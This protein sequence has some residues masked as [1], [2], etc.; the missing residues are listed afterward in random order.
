MVVGWIIMARSFFSRCFSVQMEEI[1]ALSN[2]FLAAVHGL[3][4]FS[5]EVLNTWKVKLL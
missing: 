1:I 4:L 2:V 5:H 3:P